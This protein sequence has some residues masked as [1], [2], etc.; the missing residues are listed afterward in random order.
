MDGKCFFEKTKKSFIY[1]NPKSNGPFT[2]KRL[3][4]RESQITTGL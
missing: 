1:S 4:G 2:T 3:S